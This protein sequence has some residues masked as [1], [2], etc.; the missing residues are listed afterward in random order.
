[1]KLLFKVFILLV[2]SMSFGQTNPQ[3]IGIGSDLINSAESISVL[4]YV[5]NSKFTIGFINRKHF[6]NNDLPKCVGIDSDKKT[7]L[8]IIEILINNNLLSQT[9]FFCPKF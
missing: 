8:Q 6:E 5:P 4:I 7:N 1:M 2:F 9:Y 3:N